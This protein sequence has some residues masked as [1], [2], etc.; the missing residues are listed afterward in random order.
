MNDEQIRRDIRQQI[1]KLE[2]VKKEIEHE[3]DERYKEIDQVKDE[4]FGV[5]AKIKEL[6]MR[7]LAR[8]SDTLERLS[9]GGL[10]EFAHNKQLE[11]AQE[12]IDYLKE[13]INRLRDRKSE[14]DNI[15][16]NIANQERTLLAQYET[17][18]TWFEQAD[19]YTER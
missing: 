10:Y 12:Y 13:S 5:G 15:L 7:Q 14:V 4:R 8:T 3:I 16:A 19:R 17:L 6:A 11:S 2:Q 18:K 9:G 1:E